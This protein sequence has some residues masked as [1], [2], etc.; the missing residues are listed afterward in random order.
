LPYTDVPAAAKWLCDAFGYTER[1]RIAESP[2]SA[3]LHRDPFEPEMPGIV[4]WFAQNPPKDTGAFIHA[5]VHIT[6][7]MLWVRNQNLVLFKV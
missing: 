6:R 1:L 2:H 7:L 3:S 5:K 4:E